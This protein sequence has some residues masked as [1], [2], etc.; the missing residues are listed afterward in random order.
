MQTRATQLMLGLIVCSIACAIHDSAWGDTYMAYESS[1]ESGDRDEI[2]RRTISSEEENV[3]DLKAFLEVV[4]P[5][6]AR[7]WSEEH[8]VWR[9]PFVYCSPG[10]EDN[11]QS[12]RLITKV[13]LGDFTDSGKQEA[14]VRTNS[15]EGLPGAHLIRWVDGEEEWRIL[16]SA[17]L[18]PS[19]HRRGV[20]SYDMLLCP[21]IDTWVHEY[22]YKV[23]DARASE[24]TVVDLFTVSGI[25][26]RSNIPSGER[27]R[28]VDITETES[29][30]MLNVTLIV[31]GDEPSVSS[32]HD[33][34]DVETMCQLDGSN[35]M[36]LTL[37]RDDDGFRRNLKFEQDYCEETLDG[38]VV[39]R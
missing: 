11:P 3:E 17:H 9:N 29:D 6:D 35:S 26:D 1:F 18:P 22:S 8:D 16:D 34:F 36:V 30:E 25:G 23:V 19:C 39:P 12:R 24:L 33:D 4:C 13:I 5:P 14:V 31:R 32:E 38:Q 20:G 2:D 37:S 27:P 10:S 15:A 28:S 7:I 21:S